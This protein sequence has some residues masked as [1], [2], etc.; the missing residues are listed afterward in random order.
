MPSCTTD[1]IDC[2]IRASPGDGVGVATTE[3]VEGEGISDDWGA[4][5]IDSNS[6]GMSCD[7]SHADGGAGMIGIVGRSWT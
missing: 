2:G 4:S 5:V 1:R 6:D 3:A 7:T